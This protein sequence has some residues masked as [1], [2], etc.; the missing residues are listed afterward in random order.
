MNF[1]FL[2][3]ELNSALKKSF[4]DKVY[5]IRLRCNQPIILNYDNKKVY[6]SNNGVT[7]FANDAI[8]CTKQHIENIINN[9]TEYSIY[10]Y[11]DRIKQGFLTTE[12][13]IRIG[14]AG[15]TVYDKNTI[16]TIKNISSLN[17]RVPH[18]IINC[19]NEI[20][21]KTIQNGLCNLLIVSPPGVGKTTILKDIA[22]KLNLNTNNSILLIDERGEFSTLSGQNIDNIKYCDKYYAFSYGI[23][24]MSPDVVIMD[25]LSNENDWKSAQS[26]CNSGVYVIASCHA[27]DLDNLLNKEFFIKNVFDFYVFL[28]DNG[29]KGEIK[30]IL[31]KNFIEI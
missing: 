25:E 21:L 8:I 27:K 11:N 20:Y 17:I 14:I 12:E 3:L 2:P 5:E 23:R 18:E 28:R 15:E 10:A 6:L 16:I 26:A 13:G 31:N 29:T 24:S 1:D 9:L 7:L 19:S 22:R 30:S 4:L